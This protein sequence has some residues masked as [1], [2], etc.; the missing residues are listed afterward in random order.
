VGNIEQSKL[1]LDSVGARPEFQVVLSVGQNADLDHLRPVPENIIV[2][3]SAP[4]I[5]LLKRATLCVTH[6]SLNTTLESLAQGVPMVA[7]PIG[8]DQPGTAARIAY[9]GVG[10]F[11][12]V[13]DLT[14]ARPI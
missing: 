8:Y 13:E 12:V 2:V 9:H 4:Q 10:E 5:E 3:R 1:T 11:I 14:V 7:H 6:A